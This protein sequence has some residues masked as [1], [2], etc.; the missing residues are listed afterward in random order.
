MK[1]FCKLLEKEVQGKFLYQEPM[2]NHTTFRIGGPVPLLFFPQDSIQLQGAVHLLLQKGIPYR[3]LGKGSNLL[4]CDEGLEDVVISLQDSSSPQKTSFCTIRA[5][6]GLSLSALASWAQ[7]EGL[8]GLEFLSGIPG[9]LG[10]GL[11]MNAGLKEEWL[12]SRVLEVVVLDGALHR[13]VL[14]SEDLHFTYRH[15]SL[16]LTSFIILEASF[17]LKAGSPEEIGEKMEKFRRERQEK[18]PLAFPSAGS[19][20]KN[21]AGEYAGALIDACGLKGRAVGDAMI[22]EKHANFIVNRGRARARD[23]LALIRL[24]QKQVRK[25]YAIDLELEIEVW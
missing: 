15:S 18:Q 24:I 3:L 6:A 19:V 21:P 23:V 13:R 17:G 8:T 14:K 11:V 25:N 4:V 22:S 1:D 16:R 9:T 5:S 12:G 7:G 10:G 20:F 2:K